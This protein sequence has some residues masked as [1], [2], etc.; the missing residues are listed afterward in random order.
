MLTPARSAM[1][2]VRA[3]PIPLSAISS[4]AAR[5]MRS[6]VDLAAL[7]AQAAEIRRSAVGAVEGLR[8]HQ[9]ARPLSDA[10]RPGKDQAVRKALPLQPALKPLHDFAVAVEFSKAHV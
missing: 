8:H 1:L 3:P 4:I 2:R 6:R 7:G 9:R 5:R 10:V